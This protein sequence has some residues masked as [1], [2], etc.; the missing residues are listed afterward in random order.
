M[1]LHTEYL[2][3]AMH[4]ASRKTRIPLWVFFVAAGV[5]VGFGSVCAV[6]WAWDVW[7]RHI[8]P[9]DY[10]E[11]RSLFA[12]LNWFVCSAVGWACICRISVTSRATTRWLTRASYAALLMTSSASGFG[13]LAQHW[14][15]WPELLMNCAV[16]L[17]LIDGMKRWKGGVPDDVRKPAATGPQL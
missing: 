11:S 12:L 16:L 9:I 15:G 3:E 5:V 6:Q 4:E 8:D 13:P 1:N 17:L 7:L 10:W 2:I 14:P